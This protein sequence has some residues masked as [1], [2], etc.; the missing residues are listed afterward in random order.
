M[1]MSTEDTTTITLTDARPMRVSK[2]LWPL[3]AKVSN[4]RDHNNQELSR[5]HYLRVRLHAQ[6]TEADGES[7]QYY[8]R[9]KD[10]SPRLAPHPDG[11]VIVFGWYET[12]WQGESGISGGYCCALDEAPAMIRKVGEEIGADESLIIE[13][14]GDLP[15]QVESE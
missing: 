1:K 7:M 6:K 11:R 5:R 4:D 15:P 12:S 8:G 2:A 10:A 9:D 14:I 13:C 3:V